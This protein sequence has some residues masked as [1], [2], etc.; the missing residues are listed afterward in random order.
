[1]S[2][3][4]LPLRSGSVKLGA[5]VPA[6]RPSRLMLLPETSRVFSAV[7]VAPGCAPLPSIGSPTRIVDGSTWP[8][9]LSS[10]SGGAMGS[11]VS[12]VMRLSAPIASGLAMRPSPSIR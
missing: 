5:T 3:R 10:G 11:N 9:P 8:L 7:A 6:S 4:D 12:S 2:E 1:M